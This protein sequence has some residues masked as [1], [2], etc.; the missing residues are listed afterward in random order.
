LL[1]PLDYGFVA[2]VRAIPGRGYDA[3]SRRWSVKLAN[4]RPRSVLRLI[5]HFSMGIDARDRALLSAAANVAGRFDLELALPIRGGPACVSLCDDWADAELRSLCAE[6]DALPHVEVGRLSVVI[7]HRSAAAFGDLWRR[8]EDVRW[9][10]ALARAVDRASRPQP[11]GNGPDAGSRRPA[12]GSISVRFSAGRGELE[13][14]TSAPD[15]ILRALPGSARVGPRAVEVRA[16][17]TSALYVASLLQ[18]HPDAVLSPSVASWLPQASR[19]RG[20]VTSTAEAG[21][22]TFLVVG[23]EHEPPGCLRSAEPVHP[24]AWRLPLTSAG[25][26]VLVELLSAEPQTD[27]DPCASRCL[28][29]LGD[30]PDAVV[31]PGL[32][33]VEETDDG[34]ECFALDVLWDATASEHLAALPGARPKADGVDRTD[35]VEVIADAWNATSV[36]AF[37]ADQGLEL[38]DAA[39]RLLDRLL[40]EHVEGERRVALSCAGEGS[41]SLPKTLA[42]ELMPFQVAGVEYA[43][44]RRRTFIADEQG[45]GKTIQALA[46]VEVDR[47]FPAI[48]VCPASL[49]LNW[50]RE[51][52][53]WLPHRS[54][55]VINGRSPIPLE[56]DILVLNYEILDAH[57]EALAGL[58]A[59][60]LV[61]DESHYCKNPKARR[62]Q[63]AHLLSAALPAQALRLA[64]TGTPLVNRAKELAPQLRI[65]GRLQEFG[66]ATSFE[67]TFGDSAERERLHWHLRRSCYLRR[68][69]RDVLSQ[70]PDKQRALVPVSL[71]NASDYR[72]AEASFLLWLR[73]HYRDSDDLARRL[74]S[75]M[76]AQA[77]VKV[78]ALRVLAGTGKVRVAADWIED[79][80]ASGEKLVV[81]AEHREV[82][83]KLVESFPKAT[84]ILGSD[85]QRDRDQAVHRFQ[86]DDDMRLCICSLKAAAHGLTLTAAANVAFVELG[87]TP[88]EHDQAEDRCHRIGQANAVNVWYLLAAG[89]ID[90]RVGA[91]I[92]HKRRVVRAI[93][94]GVKG[95]DRAMVDALLAGYLDSSSEDSRSSRAA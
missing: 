36:E 85:S 37:A 93:T 50:Q 1:T 82:Q 26:A 34:E 9:M 81:F 11:R 92:E 56:H 42:G 83:A 67:R 54:V 60:A 70:L 76:R 40:A 64:L 90:E 44:E 16:I 4:D 35:G 58:H 95:T 19:W 3:E 51:A 30:H 78:N 63:E 77:L 94:D 2:A 12:G 32:L 91:L 41:I 29:I 84:H 20:R 10:P 57:R 25:R 5:D 49:K 80:L 22:P 73:D 33:T 15:A 61:L 86:G 38:S 46:A 14:S 13:I 87:W 31:A 48:V 74:D 28:A 71:S 65:L 53:R 59:G 43:L 62:T 7:D 24:G 89:T 69:K 27:V 21:V 55:A 6:F 8:R 39:R 52:V 23:D 47:G 17:R 66:T 45:L 88:A 68:R 18:R 79:F 75:A 72:Q